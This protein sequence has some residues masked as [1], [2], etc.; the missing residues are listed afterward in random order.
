MKPPPFGYRRAE[1]IPQALEWYAEFEG[2][3]IWLAGG[4]S[5]V[6]SLA[7]RLQAPSALI[8]I[9]RLP[10]LSGIML[11]EAGLR[12][13]ATTTHAEILSN[14]LVRE[15]APIL[16]EAAHH[17]AHPAI[18]NRATLGGNLALA[19]PASEFPAVVRCLGAV[20]DIVGPDGE[21]EVDS[22]DFFLD[23]YTTA[24]E[25]GEILRSILI[26]RQPPS[27]R[28]R[29]SELAR[30]H[31]DFAM[32]GTAVRLLR[33][34]GRTIDARICFHAV[35]TVPVRAHSAENALT[36]HPLDLDRIR[37]A[38]DALSNDLEPADDPSMPGKM[39][40]HLA[41][42]LLGRVLHSLSDGSINREDAR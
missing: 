34:G 16:S 4:H 8:D 13:G 28:M 41:G 31:G 39:R 22:D 37:S 21:R 26:P 24:M 15:H 42:V 40:L 14:P 30:R 17:V 3:A 19:D 2:E 12:I 38:R 35:G 29:F 9:S 27:A 33:E 6:P 7:L 25:S 18:R 11:T 5:V 1:S 10:E 36:G 23:L 32:V 20:L